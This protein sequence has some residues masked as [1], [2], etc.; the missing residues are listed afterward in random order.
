MLKRYF[1]PIFMIFA[2]LT[3]LSLA[4]EAVINIEPSIEV[5]QEQRSEGIAQM[6]DAV[7]KLSVGMTK[8]EVK[9]QIGEPE[10]DYDSAYIYLFVGEEF[11]TLFFY[12][13]KQLSSSYNRY[14]LD[15]LSTEET[16]KFVD[17]TVLINDEELLT[18]NPVVTIGEKIY[19]PIE[20]MADQLG[21]EVN[22]KN[23]FA[24]SARTL[25]KKKLGVVSVLSVDEEE[26]FLKISTNVLM[27]KEKK[28]AMEDRKIGV[29]RVK[30]IVSQLKIG[31]H[32]SEVDKIIT[33]EVF[34]AMSSRHWNQ[35]KFAGDE[36]LILSYKDFTHKLESISNTNG[37]NLFLKEYMTANVDA[38]IF[39][40]NEEI[41]TSSP[42][43]LVDSHR[44]Y[45]SLQDIE[46]LFGVKAEWN[47][48]KTLLNITTKQE[49]K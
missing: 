45:F 5:T 19:L 33:E 17:F 30:E 8:D 32:S 12:E 44:I 1:L 43:M 28:L 3:V 16:A 34:W 18:T 10:K 48:E 14:G 27:T 6:K 23:I 22:R 46:E 39:I 11:I 37:F 15:L 26:Q 4:Q 29:E 47:D 41:I 35:F 20:G 7:A 2:F 31:M 9:Q 42:V 40:D 49:E 21:I 13:G 38:P 24:F 25:G 36:E